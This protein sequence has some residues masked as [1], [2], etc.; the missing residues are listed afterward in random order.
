MIF[1][2]KKLMFFEHAPNTPL[3]NLFW[4]YRMESH[5]FKKHWYNEQY[6]IT[7]VL[8]CLFMFFNSR[9]EGQNCLPADVTWSPSSLNCETFKDV[10]VCNNRFYTAT[11]GQCGGSNVCK[12]TTTRIPPVKAC[13]WAAN[14]CTAMNLKPTTNNVSCTAQGKACGETSVAMTSLCSGKPQ[15]QCQGAAQFFPS[16]GQTCPSGCKLPNSFSS[17]TCSFDHTKYKCVAV[18]GEPQQQQCQDN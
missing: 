10:G 18:V 1:S 9:L 3:S 12:P 5:V 15:G 16:G 17:G 11:I 2:F 6:L 8:G 14:K 13:K 4:G 7:L